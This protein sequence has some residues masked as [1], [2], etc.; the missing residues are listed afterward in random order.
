MRKPKNYSVKEVYDST[1][2]GFVFEFFCSKEPSFMVE[3]LKQILRKNVVLTLEEADRP[4]YTSA[5]LLKEYEGKRPRYQFKVGLQEYKEIP[6]FLNT[7]LFWINENT[8]L[9]NSTILRVK[10]DYDFKTLNT[11]NTIS[12]MDLGKLILRMDENFI[13]GKFPEMKDNPFSL[14]IKKL[15]PYNMSVNAS[16]VVNLKNQFKIP[17]NTY[18][19]IDLTEQ[20][21]G[22]IT[23]NY[24]GGS[25]YSEKVKQ[26][27][28]VLEY[29]ILTT[30]Q[31]LNS[32][33][34]TPSDVSELNRLT[35]EYRIF[36]KCYYYPKRFFEAY[37]QFEVFIDL[38]NNPNLIETQWFQVRDV[39]GKLILESGITKCKFNWDTEVGAYQVKKA[40]IKSSLIKGF[41]I[42]ESNIV[43][44][45]EDCGIWQSEI[46]DSRVVNS[47]FVNENKVSNSYLQNI[48]ADRDNKIDESFISNNGEIINCKVNNSII[49]NAGIGNM[50]KLD[51]HCL[52]VNP[53]TQDLEPSRN[54]IDVA[55]V[56]DYK[57][58]KSM[59][60][61]NYKDSG[62]ANEYKEE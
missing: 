49:K 43:G 30:Y 14:S 62:F 8:A 42:I 44:V 24:I 48:R 53:K 39:V 9:D 60:G 21:T 29:L 36:R 38:N 41:Q 15:V 10:L 33:E 3:D 50:A 46:K 26:I 7:I 37:K 31:V 23:F 58:I 16:N 34:F 51:E 57:W 4:S 19:G 18:Y 52:V 54:G 1:L 12:N 55:E 56:R 27:Y 61:P 35:E 13:H 40:E 17:M 11:L 5:V 6:T 22:D 59:R 32:Y 47:I 20:T 25:K 2:V 28:E 45:V